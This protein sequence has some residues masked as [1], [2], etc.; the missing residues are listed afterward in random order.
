VTAACAA[1]TSLSWSG[2]DPPCN[3]NAPPCPVTQI[4]GRALAGTITF[5]VAGAAPETHSVSVDNGAPILHL[6]GTCTMQNASTTIT[7]NTT[8]NPAG[9]NDV[10]V[11]CQL[12]NSSLG[13]SLY[14]P[15][16]DLRMLG[17]GTYAIP[18]GEV[19]MG[20]ANTS[21]T[22]P[23]GEGTATLVVT[24]AEGG[25]APYPAAV[26]PDYVREFS[27]HIEAQ[28]AR[29]TTPRGCTTPDAS[30]TVDLQFAETAADAVNHPDV[31]CLC[32]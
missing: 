14:L 32:G 2:C 16:L 11:G 29:S 24:R 6:P 31:T 25:P 4:T 18:P 15:S 7:P 21:C 20:V 10:G 19:G 12:S 13:V 27:V 26:T 23:V 3:A 8:G 1:V 28:V 9:L 17:V 30:A 5:A 22:S